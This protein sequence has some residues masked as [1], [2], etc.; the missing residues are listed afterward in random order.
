MPKDTAPIEKFKVEI[1]SVFMR[2][3]EESDLD[4]EDMAE[5]V[6]D[7]CEAFCGTSIG[8][9]SEIDLEDDEDE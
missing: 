9:E 2:W 4:E 6:I 1:K 7:V 8:F 3:W 5:A